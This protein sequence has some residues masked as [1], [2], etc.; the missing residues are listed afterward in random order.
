MLTRIRLNH[1]PITPQ[2]YVKK[3]GS[4]SYVIPEYFP[5][6]EARRRARNSA[7]LHRLPFVFRSAVSAVLSVRK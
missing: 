5:F 7:V 4:K 2:E 1:H 3:S 6:D